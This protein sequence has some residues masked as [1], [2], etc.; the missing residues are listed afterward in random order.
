MYRLVRNLLYMLGVLAVAA[1]SSSSPEDALNE[2]AERLQASLESRQ[3][4]AAARQLHDDFLAQQHYNRQAA[5]QQM[6]GLFMRYKNVN[7]L[8]VN[9]QCQLDTGFNY[10]GQCTAQVAVTGAQGLIPERLE[11]YRVNSV[12]ELEEGEWL[13][14]R[15]DWE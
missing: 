5:R 6:L 13:L 9:R 14:Y 8:V 3:A 4:G 1:C 15:L 10:R 7:I 2:A 12:W 11:Y